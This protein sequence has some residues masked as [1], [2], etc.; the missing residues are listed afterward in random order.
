[1]IKSKKLFLVALLACIIGSLNAQTDSPYSRYGY[2][3]LRDQA[4][5]PSKAMVE[6]DTDFAVHKAPIL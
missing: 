3:I 5:G 2:G 6:L 4:V 1:M